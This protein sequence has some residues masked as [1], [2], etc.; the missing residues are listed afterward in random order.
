MAWFTGPGSPPRYSSR[1][2]PSRHSSTSHSRRRPR[3]GY[4][5]RLVHQIKKLMHNLYGYTHRHP[6]K[7]FMLVVMPLITGGALHSIL[8]TFGVRVPASVSRAMGGMGGMANERNTYGRYGGDFS[9]G[10]R[11]I[12]GDLGGGDALQSILKI[13]QMLI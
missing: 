10:R 7:V 3:N 4:I 2:S 5:N 12:S 11:E 8:K 13:A 1:P 9:G 6:V